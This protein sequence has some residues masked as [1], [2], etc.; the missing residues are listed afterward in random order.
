VAER[1]TGSLRA[2]TLE[3]GARRRALALSYVL[4]VGTGAMDAIGFARLGDVFTSVMTGNL[5][6]LGVSVGS[7]DDELAVRIAIA[8]GAFVVGVMAGAR[9][10]ATKPIQP[11]DTG[12]RAVWPAGVNRTLVVQ[13][14]VMTAFLVGWE[15][16]SGSPDNEAQVLLLVLAA[17]AMGLQSGAVLKI[18]TKGLPTTYVTG[19]LTNVLADLATKGRLHWPGIGTLFAL[20]SGAAAAGILI[21]HADRWAAVLPYVA[22]VTVLIVAWRSRRAG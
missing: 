16:S 4:T 5:V 20:L 21:F 6:L 1:F 3:E 19:T 12:F 15:R 2:V 22:L 10:T 18:G 7:Q 9:I 14:V 13:L 11:D 8:F 17:T